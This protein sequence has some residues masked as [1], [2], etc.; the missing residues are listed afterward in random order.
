LASVL[1]EQFDADLHGVYAASPNPGWDNR[2][3]RV[4]R[5]IVEHN[6]REQLTSLL[7]PFASA[8]AVDSFVTRGTAVDVI[9]AHADA[10]EAELIVCGISGSSRVGEGSRR[11]ASAVASRATP[12]VLT[13]PGDTPACALRRILLVV[14]EPD[15]TE[16]A[17]TWAETLAERFGASISLVRLAQAARG[18]WPAFGTGL[19]EQMFE[20]KR[21]ATL[22]LAATSVMDA[23]LDLGKPLAPERDANGIAALAE[24]DAFDLVVIGLPPTARRAD[25]ATA[26]VERLR[27]S[28]A[29]PTLSVR[30]PSPALQF[31]PQTDLGFVHAFGPPFDQSA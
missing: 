10:H 26:L 23:E 17:L 30:A 31:L 2:L 9:L 13:V 6:A 8:L 27:R 3:E 21:K 29:V 28:S 16:A 19:R 24:R 4:K 11:L 14:T 7:A 15:A 1:A 5:L 25:P 22:Q 18:F 20:R 12:A